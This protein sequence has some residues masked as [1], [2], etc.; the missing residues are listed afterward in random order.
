MEDFI[1][2]IETNRAL[3]K[4]L[5]EKKIFFVTPLSRGGLLDNPDLIEI[6]R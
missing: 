5:R 6:N 4:F 3:L 1:S 2:F